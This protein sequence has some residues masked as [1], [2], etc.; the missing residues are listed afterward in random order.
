M[1]KI[2]INENKFK[3]HSKMFTIQLLNI[4]MIIFKNQTTDNFSR[5]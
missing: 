4:N 3:V 5:T 2:I 1:K